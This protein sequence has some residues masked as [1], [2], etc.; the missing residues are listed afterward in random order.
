[1]IGPVDLEQAMTLCNQCGN[2]VEDGMSF[3]TE[4]G[5]RLNFVRQSAELTKPIA[6]PPPAP[7]AEQ[8]GDLTSPISSPRSPQQTE[9]PPPDTKPL[10]SREEEMPA[11]FSSPEEEKP[12]Q[13]QPQYEPQYQPEYQP[14]PQPQYEPARKDT[15]KRNLFIIASAV[16]LLLVVAG[17]VV[18]A[19]R[20]SSN[21]PPVV[22]SIDVDKTTILPGEEVNVTARATDTGDAQLNYEWAT[23][24]G[25]IVGEGSNVVLNTWGVDPGTEALNVVITLTVKDSAGELAS[26]TRSI[27]IIP[28]SS[29]VAETGNTTDPLAAPMQLKIIADKRAVQRGEAV[30]LKAEVENREAAELSFDW[31]TSAGS[32]Q[33]NGNSATLQT[34]AIQLTGTSQQVF[35]TVT[36]RDGR[37][38][39][40]S[41]NQPINIMES[42]PRNWPP[43]VELIASRSRVRQGEEVV[44]SA[45]AS[46][47]DGDPLSYSWSSSAGQLT[48]SGNSYTL[49]TSS[50][51]PGQVEVRATVADGRGETA[52]ARVVITVTERPNNSPSIGQIDIVPASVNP[53]ERVSVRASA[54]DPDGDE[55]RYQ[56][57]TSGGTIRG[58]GPD[59]VLD[60]TGVNA[61]SGPVQVTV[62][63]TVTDQRGGVATGSR[64]LR[65]ILIMAP[66]RPG[67]ISVSAGQEGEDL[68]VNLSNSPGR[69]DSQ[70]GS[71]R[72]AIGAFGSE[73]Q[74]SGF[75]PGVP[76]RV[77]FDHKDNVDEISFIETPGPANRYS[78]ARVRV[79]PK[80]PRKP[81][82]FVIIWRAL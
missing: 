49:K 33:S 31:K 58:S 44:I 16:L 48:G 24:V 67:T 69:A 23:S 65:V 22:Q 7:Y 70:S 42:A 15:N 27:T 60:T 43:T 18:L 76:C 8:T 56:W 11:Q 55:L 2:V 45:S 12:A 78:R 34:S 82:R 39:V 35:V 13:Y 80:H 29:T 50:I 66:P 68:I 14:Q 52:T 37:G 71:V 73:R 41:L 17:A 26:G 74:A 54:T 28:E 40:K 36:V 21:D 81:V 53:G 59:V 51:N 62:S 63:L 6:S 32:I 10:S 72:V 25:K 30:N 5:A 20:K 64:S 75:F 3:C 4:C 79:R 46:D 38:A 1:M 19:L 47:R 57:S 9:P 61:S 77:S